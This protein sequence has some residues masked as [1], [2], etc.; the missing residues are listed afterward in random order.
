MKWPQNS[1]VVHWQ[2]AF[3]ISASVILILTGTAKV[4]STFGK[5]EVLNLADPIFG[6]PF[7][8][9][10]LLTGLVDLIT[11]L[12]CIFNANQK[13]NEYCIIWIV[14]N[15]LL[16]R[17]GLKCVGWHRPCSCLGNITGA[18]GLSPQRADLIMTW[19]LAYLVAG[20]AAILINKQLNINSR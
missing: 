16:Y 15:F 11:A 5:A 8:N 1:I 17:V 3:I 13:L 4:V 9:L 10:M 19:V 2:K 20:I 12:F 6:I 7:R 14:V 18:I